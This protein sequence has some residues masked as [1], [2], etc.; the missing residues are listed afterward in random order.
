LFAAEARKT[1]RKTPDPSLQGNRA[2]VKWACGARKKER[3]GRKVAG[4][5]KRKRRDSRSV[6]TKVG[7]MV[8]EVKDWNL[9]LHFC[10]DPNLSLP[11]TS[12][13]IGQ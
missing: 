12:Y 13:C 1:E 10:S 6:R 3:K 2:A 7:A 9:G 4:G 8:S 5:G 11:Q